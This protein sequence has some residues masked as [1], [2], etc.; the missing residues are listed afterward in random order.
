MAVTVAPTRES[1]VMLF[2]LDGMLAVYVPVAGDGGL[3]EIVY[4]KVVELTSPMLKVPFSSGELA[5]WIVTDW[6]FVSA[7]V[8]AADSTAVTVAP[9]RLND[10]IVVLGG[11]IPNDASVSDAFVVANGVADRLAPLAHEPVLPVQVYTL[12]GEDGLAV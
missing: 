10:D 2:G 7:G 5:P 6:P 3:T 11:E 4:V 9:D 1:D 12:R 8:G